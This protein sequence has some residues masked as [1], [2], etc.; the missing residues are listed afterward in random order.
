MNQIIRRSQKLV[1]ESETLRDMT[2][3]NFQEWLIEAKTILNEH[4][5]TVKHRTAGERRKIK[6]HPGMVNLGRQL[7]FLPFLV[8][9]I[10]VIICGVSRN[11][12]KGH[13]LLFGLS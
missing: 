7:K 2:N 3:F 1:S 11:K 12:Q 5:Y 9:F 8:L 4:G 10:Q 13:L 6:K